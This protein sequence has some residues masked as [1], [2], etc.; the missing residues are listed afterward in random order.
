[1]RSPLPFPPKLLAAAFL[2]LALAACQ[3]GSS[4]RAVPS[5][6][7]IGSGLKCSAGDHP[8]GDQ[9]T[10]WAF[11]YPDTWRYTEKSQATESPS[12]VDLTFDI[13]CLTDCK[14]PCPTPSSGQ[15]AA[16]C[17]PE[18]GLFGFMIISTYDRGSSSD[19]ASWLS[20]NLPHA[21]TGDTIAWGNSLEAVQLTDGRRVALTPHYVVILDLHPSP[22]DLEGEMSSR[23]GTWKFSY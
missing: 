1:M 6:P 19:L 12:G 11:C 17:T 22:L 13:T 14:P 10:G 21:A 16:P 15:P 8:Y 7:Q 2:V 4:P 9:Q 5:V 23:L 20:A 3:V 18:N